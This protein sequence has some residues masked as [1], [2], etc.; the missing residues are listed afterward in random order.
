MAERFNQKQIYFNSIESSGVVSVSQLISLISEHPYE[1]HIRKA[2]NLESIKGEKIV[3]G[4]VDVLFKKIA[5]IKN[6]YTFYTVKSYAKDISFSRGNSKIDGIRDEKPIMFNFSEFIDDE[7]EIKNGFSAYAVYDSKSKF[8]ED[9]SMSKYANMLF[10]NRLDE[11]AEINLNYFRSLSESSFNKHHS[12]RMVEHNDQQFVRGI[13]S[14]KYREY[15]V[16]FSFVVAILMLNK[17]MKN[18]LGN[19]YSISFAA[20]NESKLEMIITSDDSKKADD[21]G[22]VRSAISIKTNDLG[23][24]ALTFTNIIR[25]DVKGDGIYL[26]PNNKDVARKDITINHGNTSIKSAL[27]QISNAEDFYGYIDY[28]IKELSAIKTIKSPEELR[29]RILIK[30]SQ[31]TSSLK[32]VS[33]ELKEL[34]K[35]PIK[36]VIEDFSKFLEMCKKAE[37]LEIEYDLKEK[38]RVIISDVILNKK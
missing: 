27:G 21:F 36:D 1:D 29:K 23:G 6:E 8:F 31:P 15:G 5:A 10:D 2:F 4:N 24:G 38:L 13:T 32:N 7:G 22:T 20:V 35:N 19:N 9:Y 11:L 17:H 30:L 12:Y 16:D 33:K 3:V 25:L 28:F 26:Y 34:F 37:Q 14:V 18:N